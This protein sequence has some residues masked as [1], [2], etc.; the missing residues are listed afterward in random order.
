MKQTIMQTLSL[1]IHHRWLMVACLVGLAFSAGKLA[2]STD[3]N[4]YCPAATQSCKPAT[5]CR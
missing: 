5:F 1:L 2:G 4:G 3:S